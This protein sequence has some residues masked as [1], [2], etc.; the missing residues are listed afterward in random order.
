MPRLTPLDARLYDYL[1]GVSVREPALLKRLREETAPMRWSMMQIGP[2]QGQFMSLLLRMLAATR[3]I[4]VGVFTGYSSLVTAL[5]LP[6]D[7]ELIACDVNAE[8][9]SIARRYWRE[10]RVDHKI[11][12]H[13]APARETLQ[14]LCEQGRES[15]FDFAFV[16]A[17]KGSYADYYAL[18][19][20][21]VR[22][23]GLIAFDNTLWGGAVADPDD[24]SDDTEALRRFN[25][26]L[27]DDDR[28]HLSL[29]PI[30]DGLTLALRK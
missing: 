6:D 16:D 17:D 9:T 3:T 19:L 30:G 15:E 25:L 1:L 7:G 14:M 20:R 24:R 26:L 10:A 23:G 2:E 5:A 8:W 12:L 28:V 18:C 22:P 27:R 13:L 29:V 4:E 21:L 11:R